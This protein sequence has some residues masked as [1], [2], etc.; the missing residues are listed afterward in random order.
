MKLYIEKYIQNI[1][2]YLYFFK[3]IFEIIFFQCI[4]KIY[5]VSLTI[6]LF[7][8]SEKLKIKS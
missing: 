6:F 5:F 7:Q 1:L 3:N 8:K 2:E 4:A